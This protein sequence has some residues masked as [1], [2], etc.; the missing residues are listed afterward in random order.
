MID[1]TATKGKT[2]TPASKLV[3]HIANLA[4]F[5]AVAPKVTPARVTLTFTDDETG[6]EYTAAMPLAAVVNSKGLSGA[7]ADKSTGFWIGAPLVLDTPHG[8]VRFNLGGNVLVS[9]SKEA[10]KAAASASA[11]KEAI[12]AERK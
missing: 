10:A 7:G 6:E 12:A 2:N 3:R 4:A 11:R 5:Q 8:E 1:L 9:G